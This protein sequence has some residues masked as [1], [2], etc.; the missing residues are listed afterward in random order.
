MFVC[1]YH[2]CSPLLRDGHNLRIIIKFFRYSIIHNERNSQSF[3]AITRRRV[4]VNSRN[5]NTIQEIQVLCRHAVSLDLPK[6][7]TDSTTLQ[8][9]KNE[10]VRS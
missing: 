5:M 9:L 4:Y 8:V 1:H 2:A 3:M 7:K 10:H 6:N